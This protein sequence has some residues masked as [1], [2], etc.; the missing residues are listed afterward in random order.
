MK[1]CTGP[2]LMIFRY[3]DRNWFR[4]RIEVSSF[5]DGNGTFASGFSLNCY[6]F[7]YPF[8]LSLQLFHPIVRYTEIYWLILF[9]SMI[10]IPHSRLDRWWEA[11]RNLSRKGFHDETAF[12]YPPVPFNTRCHAFSG[13]MRMFHV[14]LDCQPE[15]GIRG[16]LQKRA[17][18]LTLKRESP[19][20]LDAGWGSRLLYSAVR[21]EG[22]RIPE[23]RAI[24]VSLR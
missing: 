22:C 7:S 9:I 15:T 3:E 10:L 5:Y 8:I 16:Q 12:C 1:S 13:G 21:K 18:H 17:P 4:F 6:I 11:F 2:G 24:L 23:N 19:C 14:S 20:R